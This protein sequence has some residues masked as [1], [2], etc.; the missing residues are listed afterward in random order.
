MVA[1][2]VSERLWDQMWRNAMSDCRF[3]RYTG[4]AHNMLACPEAMAGE[5]KAT[6]KAAWNDG[7][8]NARQGKERPADDANPSYRL[9][10]HQ[11]E[12]ALEA[13]QNGEP[14]SDPSVGF[15]GAKFDDVR[16]DDFDD[17]DWGHSN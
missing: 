7:Y 3:C 5:K 6:A 15:K 13:A 14:W 4:G 11:G 16:L 10:Y 12:I 2:K 1:R 8:H 9:G 17:P